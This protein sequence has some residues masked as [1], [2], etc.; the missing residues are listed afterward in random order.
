MALKGVKKPL[1]FSLEAT[2]LFAMSENLIKPVE[3]GDFGDTQMRKSTIW[4][5][6]AGVHDYFIQRRRLIEQKPF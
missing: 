4:P 1:G 5:A 2:W 3:N 6:S